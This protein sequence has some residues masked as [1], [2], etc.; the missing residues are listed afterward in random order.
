MMT[1][2]IDQILI[3]NENLKQENSSLKT[4][5]AERDAE[6]N[7]LKEAMRLSRE[8]MFGS[9]SEK[10]P[11]GQLS[12]GFFDEAEKESNLKAEEPTVERVTKKKRTSRTENL[13][14]LETEVTE[15][16]LPEDKLLCPKCNT[17]LK[18]ITVETRE[19]IKL[20]KKVIRHLEKRA[21]YACPKCDLFVKADMP[22]L[23]IEGSLA[24]ASTLSQVIVDKFANHLPLYRQSQD[25]ERIGLSLS[26]QNL[27]NWILKSSDLLDIV[28]QKM[29]NEL[30]S[31]DILHADETTVQVLKES[32]KAAK[33]KSY[34]WLYQTGRYDTPIVIYDYHPSRSGKIPQAFLKDFSGYLHV[35]GYSGYNHMDNV[36]LVGCLAHV[37]RYFNDAYKLIENTEDAK[38]SNTAKGLAYCNKLFSL[39]KES[40]T[41]ELKDRYIFKQ[42]KIKPMFDEF[43]TW[44]NQASINAL[45]QSKYGKAITYALNQMPNLMHYL[46]R[47]ELDIDNNR[48]ERSIKPF[49]TGRKNWLFNHSIDGAEASA[50]LYSIVQT[51]ML[52]NVNPYNYL[53]DTLTKLANM[54]INQD[55]DIES[56]LPWKYQT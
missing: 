24:D 21:V 44:L 39:E 11:D 10:T 4:V 12:L 54:T 5:L 18:K 22:K 32:G 13:S 7:L 51:C 28:Y 34:M 23:P 19:T 52:N 9:S 46:D 14:H 25:F 35:D 42:E 8:K 48:A 47:A 56:L 1:E 31:K 3:E 30:L 16:T 45:P 50:R 2:N 15:Y 17:P 27:S 33:S 20:Y 53:S 55:T 43:L 49:V 26:R 41:L 37:K 6:I 40:K 36:T 38:Q 29:K